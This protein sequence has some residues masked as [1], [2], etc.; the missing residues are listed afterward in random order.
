MSEKLNKIYL[1]TKVLGTAMPIVTALLAADRI[2][3][4]EMTLSD[5]ENGICNSEYNIKNQT[6]KE[7]IL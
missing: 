1:E 6:E 5:F 2:K 7:H 4:K 3:S